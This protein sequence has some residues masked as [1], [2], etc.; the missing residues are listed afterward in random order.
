MVV[1]ISSYSS[2][3]PCCRCNWERT[4]RYFD[5]TGCTSVFF[6]DFWFFFFLH[7]V[8]HSEA[9]YRSIVSDRVRHSYRL[10]QDGLWFQ[11]FKDI[12]MDTLIYTPQQ[13]LRWCV[14][15]L[16]RCNTNTS[17]SEKNKAAGPNSDCGSIGRPAKYGKII[18]LFEMRNGLVPH[19]I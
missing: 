19:L 12:Q 9:T 11:S 5:F 7:V 10:L 15:L 18:P 4:S 3:L 8:V 6:F 1:S 16:W 2:S 13:L 17:R 14:L